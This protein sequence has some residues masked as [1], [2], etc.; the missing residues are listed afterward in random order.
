MTKTLL[1]I[2]PINHKLT[3]AH[4]VQDFYGDGKDGVF[5]GRVW[6]MDRIQI[7]QPAQSGEGVEASAISERM[8][9]IGTTG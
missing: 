8:V 7:V 1:C 5:F 4:V 3:E 6:P 2:N 9:R